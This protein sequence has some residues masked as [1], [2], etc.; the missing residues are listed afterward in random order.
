MTSLTEFSKHSNLL[1]R[2]ARLI[3]AVETGDKKTL[4]NELIQLDKIQIECMLFGDITAIV[5]HRN[6]V[7]AKLNA[8]G[9][10]NAD[11]QVLV[12]GD[13][14]LSMKEA[15]EVV[16]FK[17]HLLS[18][19]V[20]HQ[21]VFDNL[22]KY[23]PWEMHPVKQPLN[24]EILIHTWVGAGRFDLALPLLDELIATSRHPHAI[25]GVILDTLKQATQSKNSAKALGPFLKWVGVQEASIVA[26]SPNALPA[27]S[28]IT[29]DV[30]I[31]VAKSGFRE[32][33]DLIAKNTDKFPDQGDLYRLRAE[34]DIVLSDE[35]IRA[36]WSNPGETSQITPGKMIALIMYTLAFEDAPIPDQINTANHDRILH[37]IDLSL[38][39][40]KVSGVAHEPA[41]IGFVL[42]H[43]WKKDSSHFKILKAQKWPDELKMSCEGY[44]TYHL[45]VDLG[46]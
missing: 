13:K 26:L 11:M 44:A 42:D 20:F 9:D 43:W 1:E 38:N 18:A 2:E 25:Q 31:N 39:I 46:L 37:F 8:M 12:I 40:L 41:R 30:I 29:F 23:R 16:Q 34:A 7:L 33:A 10:S 21:C 36:L 5:E 4:E 15:C 27:A 3:R 28:D 22:M 32:F 14:G 6:A 19:D 45:E 24:V 17:R 35:R